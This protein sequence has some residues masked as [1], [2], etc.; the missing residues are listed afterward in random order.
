VVGVTESGASVTLAAGDVRAVV[1]R[2]SGLVRS[3]R[4]GDRELL[5]APLAPDFWR[6]P[7]DNDFGAGAQV[8]QAVWRDAGAGFEVG[9]V[10]VVRGSASAQVVVTGALAAGPTPLTLRYRMRADGVLE[11][12]QEMQP[13]EG[14]S[15][16]RLA[17]FGMRTRLPSRYHAT[18]W[19]GRG[20]GESYQDRTDG[21]RLG[22]WSLDV[23]DWAFPYVRP[24]ETGNRTGVRWLALRDDDGFGLLV[25]GEPEVEA[26]AIP[27]AR[28]DLDPGDEKAQRHWAELR[29]RD[30]IFLNVDFKQMGVA[31]IDSWGA[32]AL[33]RYTL[34][35][36]PYGYSFR[37]RPLRPGEDAAVEGRALRKTVVG[38]AESISR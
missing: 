22:R 4:V 2:R 33:P 29:P 27:Y 30:A 36:G 34:P 20:P 10:E 1:D 32:T 9:G 19:Y 13:A 24:Q 18:E 31:G 16:P 23:A 14:E 5:E 12:T 38:S 37:L 26:T 21:E 6:A 8:E 7:N 17:R 11:V 3:Y 28:E 35:Y 25:A 15:L